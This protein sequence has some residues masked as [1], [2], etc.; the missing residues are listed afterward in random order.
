MKTWVA[1]FLLLLAVALA[2][3][4]SRDLLSRKRGT[5]K[6]VVTALDTGRAVP[7]WFPPGPP[8]FTVRLADGRLVGVATKTPHSAAV[9]NQIMVTEWVTPWG[10]LWYTQRD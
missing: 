5:L 4:I 6:G 7:K 2:W 1:L 10:Q 8:R 3:G 9:G